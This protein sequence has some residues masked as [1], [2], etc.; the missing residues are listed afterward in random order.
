V[1]RWT[2]RSLASSQL[3]IDPRTLGLTRILIA[4]LLLFDL[5][6]RAFAIATW[7]GNSGLLPNHTLLSHPGRTWQL[8]FLWMFS[9]GQEVAIAFAL[10]AGVYLALLVGYRTRLSQVLAL[11]CLISLHVR[12]DILANG[13]DFA[14]CALLWWT[15]FLPMGRRF[16][17]DAL[18]QSLRTVERTPQA[19][20]AFAA[21]PRDTAP[22]WSL[23]VLA[24]TTQLA[25]IYFFNAVQKQGPTWSEGTAI[26]YLLQQERILAP[27]GLWARHHLPFA[28]TQ[29]LTYAT[30]AIE[31]VLPFLILS[32][33]GRPWTRRVAILLIW[34]LHIDIGLLVNV[35]VFSPVMCVFGTLLLTA[36]DWDALSAWATRR[37][38]RTVYYDDACGVCSQVARLVAGLDLFSRIDL[39]AISEVRPEDLPSDFDPALLK[40]TLLVVDPT[41]GRH[42]V[43]AAAC[44]EILSSLPLGHLAGWA[45]K[46]PGLRGL[47]DRFYDA[48]SRHRMRI[49]IFFGYAACGPAG[50][51]TASAT[52]PPQ[53]SNAARLRTGLRIALR[54]ATVLFLIV[55]A[56]A[57]LLH[58]NWAVPDFLELRRLPTWIEASVSYTRLQQGWTMFAPD[59]PVEERNLIVIGETVDGRKVDPVRAAASDSDA[60]YAARVVV[61]PGY[62]VYWVDYIERIEGRR[63]YHE[64]LRDWIMAH[65]ERTGNPKDRVTR[66]EALMVEQESPPPGESDPRNFRIRRILEGP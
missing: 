47:A 40:Q 56:T 2:L 6:K 8:S 44:G 14:F 23:A 25:V 12:V 55:V 19:L 51:S 26:H 18:R 11:V 48:F 41:T 17:V 33:F 62:D 42:H 59:A 16:S 64:A 36:T 60:P 54:E 66:F 10:I 24:V 50:T 20:R 22:V 28:V 52:A 39:R 37:R 3:C 13:G 57:Q 58:E 45:L 30:L 5:G 46:A 32:P 4:L 34:G 63:A 29:A 35:G 27:L 43:G 65:H 21:R 7:Y 31:G 49:S 61:Q 53:P 1:R 38:R 15:V 9:H